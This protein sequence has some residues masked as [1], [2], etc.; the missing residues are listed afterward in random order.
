M[1]VLESLGYVKDLSAIFVLRIECT[2][3]TENRHLGTVLDTGQYFRFPSMV[4][5][6]RFWIDYSQDARRLRKARRSGE[7]ADAM[8]Q[9]LWKTPGR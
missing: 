2:C 7:K 3:K 1:Q 9:S 6:R 5:L 8:S 4:K